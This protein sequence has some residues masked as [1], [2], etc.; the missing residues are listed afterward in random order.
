MRSRPVFLAVLGLLAV[1]LVGCAPHAEPDWAVAEGAAQQFERA[2]L[3]EEGFL[4]SAILRTDGAESQSSAENEV[5]LSYAAEVRVDGA[6]VAC[7]GEGA[8]RL[9]LTVRVGSSW[10]G[11]P[12]AEI[13][14][15]GVDHALDLDGPL[16][17]VNAVAINAARTDG[18]GGVLVAVVSGVGSPGELAP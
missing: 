3:T 8:V 15:D 7:F 12:S 2:A 11:T 1:G 13:E 18:A 6:T 4:G 17:G 10:L 16:E 14:C 5:V 9:G